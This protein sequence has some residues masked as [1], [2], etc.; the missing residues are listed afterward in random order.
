MSWDAVL[1]QLR[2]D[3]RFSDSPLPKDQQL[4]LFHSHMHQLR[5]KHLNSLHA[6]FNAHAPS[7]AASLSQLPVESIEKS[8]PA[9]K[10]GFDS[11]ELEREFDK[12]QRDRTSDARKA[13]DEMLSENAFVEFWGRLKKMG[14][15]GADG[16]VAAE[17]LGED[18]GECFG[19]KVDMKALAKN[20]DLEE[21]IKVLKVRVFWGRLDSVS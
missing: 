12:W 5:L 20:V 6:L 21:I 17:D 8:S 3:P 15:E 16:G 7:L 19:G 13:F 9:T 10:L 11:R 1:P 18:E 4:H 14:G 2:T